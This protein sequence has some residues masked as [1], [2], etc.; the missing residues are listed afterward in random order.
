MIKYLR[1]L[2][3]EL[4]KTKWI[5]FLFGLVL[6]FVFLFKSDYSFS[7]KHIEKISDN[8]GIL[9]TK[10]AYTV[11]TVNKVFL[12]YGDVGRADYTKF[13][14]LDMFFPIA[15]SLFLAAILFRLFA[16]SK[17]NPYLFAIFAA[18][19][20]YIENILLF[21]INYTFP[22]F[23]NNIVYI[24]SFSTSLKWSFIIISFVII[25]VGG[26][27]NFIKKR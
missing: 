1:K 13:Q 12:S 17:Y 21:N 9:D 20:D 26:V 10:F 23:S 15:Y 4:S 14:I 7:S 2:L 24:S 16:K 5:I 11:E 22:N 27:N 6:V 18:I 19:F 8:N 3:T 25:V